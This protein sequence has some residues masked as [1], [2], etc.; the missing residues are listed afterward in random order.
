MVDSRVE[1]RRQRALKVAGVTGAET[2]AP[3]G[4]PYAAFGKGVNEVLDKAQGDRF[5]VFGDTDHGSTEKYKALG[6]P[7]ALNA[8]KDHDVKVIA[9]ETR[10]EFQGFAD[11]LKDD[12]YSPE[13]Y[14]KDVASEYSRV[15]GDGGDKNAKEALAKSGLPKEAV[16]GSIESKTLEEGKLIKNAWSKG[17]RPACVEGQFPSLGAHTEGV[18]TQYMA[19]KEKN[20]VV[21]AWKEKIDQAPP[22]EKAKLE[23]GMKDAKAK[24]DAKSSS[25]EEARAKHDLALSE[26]IKTAANGDK[27]VVLYGNSHG[28]GANDLDE[29]LGAKRVDLAMSDQSAKNQAA[30]YAAMR[31]PDFKGPKIADPPE[32]IL[33]TTGAL[34]WVKG[35]E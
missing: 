24:L 5:T 12:S 21:G 32:A 15:L 10:H 25:W 17:I 6:S 26:N 14:A 16:L 13:Q 1:E 30:L 4:G 31:E 22:N 3:S 18:L 8:L 19:I 29:F 27:T 33:S 7:E 35:K 2:V 9:L 34:E 28:K 11:K 20:E 23:A